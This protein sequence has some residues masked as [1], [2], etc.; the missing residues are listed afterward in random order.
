VCDGWRLL[1]GGNETEDGVADRGGHSNGADERPSNDLTC[2][3]VLGECRDE[4]RADQQEGYQSLGVAGKIPFKH[5]VRP[6]NM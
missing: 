5:V 3:K 1:V 2:S 4:N 6:F